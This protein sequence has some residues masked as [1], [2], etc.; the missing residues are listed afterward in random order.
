ME[1]WYDAYP[2]GLA[3]HGGSLYIAGSFVVDALGQVGMV[4]RLDGD[5]WTFVGNGPDEPFLNIV[6]IASAGGQLMVGGLVGSPFN[7]I[8]AWD[9]SV[10]HPVGG[11][12]T[13]GN[14]IAAIAQHGTDVIAAGSFT[15][16]AGAPCANIAA[17]NPVTGWRALDSGLSGWVSDLLSRNGVLYAAGG[18]GRAGNVSAPGIARW[19]NGHWAALPPLPGPLG[20]SPFVSALGWFDGHLVASGQGF[21]SNIAFLGSDSTWHALGSGL[22]QPASAFAELGSSLFV[23]GN[24]SEAG[25]EPAYGIAEW[26]EEGSAPMPGLPRVSAAPNPFATDVHLRYELAAPGQAR[27]EIYDLAG[28]RVERA[29]EGYQEAGPQDVVWRPEGVHVKAG[30]YF[31]RLLIAGE[32]RVVRVVRIQ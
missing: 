24:F 4:A 7:G 26:V 1:S 31:A 16:M 23:G 9:G 22:N 30:V 11:G 28:H 20:W 6:C 32:S 19:Q 2:A 13:N 21:G 29:F 17:W 25:G 5:H 14:W 27:I 3:V 8:A 15:E 12:V 18:F 10:W